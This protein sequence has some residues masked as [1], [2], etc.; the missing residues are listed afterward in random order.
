MR[1]PVRK[2]NGGAI[3]SGAGSHATSIVD[4]KAK[5]QLYGNL[6][7][8]RHLTVESKISDAVEAHADTKSYGSVDA[9]ALSNTR[10]AQSFTS[11]IDVDQG[12]RLSAGDSIELN[13]YTYLDDMMTSNTHSG[14]TVRNVQSQSGKWQW[15][16][17]R[18]SGQC[19]HNGD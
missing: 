19:Q 5:V 16:S 14:A 11:V 18:R 17:H 8:N 7:A 10:I 2:P 4:H 3:V 6:H 13:A 9:N 12:A 15:Y 1:M